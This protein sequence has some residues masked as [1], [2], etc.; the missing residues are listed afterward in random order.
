MTAERGE[1]TPAPSTSS[2]ADAS[3]VVSTST[4][5]PINHLLVDSSFALR[6]PWCDL[7]SPM[8]P[9]Q[10]LL[11]V[12]CIPLLIWRLFLTAIILPQVHL[13]FSLLVAGQDLGAPLSPWRA[14]LAGALLRF[15]SGGLL[16]LGFGLYPRIKNESREWRERVAEA[17]RERA[18]IV[19][20]HTSYLDGLAVTHLLQPCCA[21]KAQVATMPFFGVWSRALQ[22]LFIDREIAVLSNG[23]GNGGARKGEG[24]GV[25]VVGAAAKMAQR[26]ADPR[27]PLLAVS[28]E[29]TTKPSH[30]LLKFKSGAFVSG[31]P[32]LPLCLDYRRKR[33]VTKG[34]KGEKDEK[35]FSSLVGKLVDSVVSLSNFNPGW[36]LLHS[37]GFHVLRAYMSPWT[38]LRVEA[39]P[40]MRPRKR[41]EE[42]VGEDET[43]SEF[44]E[45]VREAMSLALDAPRVDFGVEDWAR[46]KA[47]GVAV[48]PWGKTVLWRPRGAGT[49]REPVVVDG[50]GIGDDAKKNA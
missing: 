25:A 44:A 15:W 8:T 2:V 23:K 7:D 3:V 12:L 31:R 46:L 4:S 21:A 14:R 17:E 48:D 22:F 50:G 47:S 37:D 49:E 24:G 34:G 19:F 16:F 30:C 42:G 45:R 5:K 9:F 1:T 27:F 29:A 6:N 39:L 32:V 11:M 28:P 20:N 40:L 13:S 10:C 38:R 18:V 33:V 41:G 43:P 36:G 26:A 35:P